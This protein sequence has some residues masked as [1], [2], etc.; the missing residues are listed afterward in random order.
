MVLFGNVSDIAAGYG[1]I[2]EHL[3]CCGTLREFLR[4]LGRVRKRPF[5][6]L[7]SPTFV[8][9]RARSKQTSSKLEPCL[10]LR[11]KSTSWTSTSW[12]LASIPAPHEA[13]PAG[14]ASFRRCQLAGEGCEGCAMGVWLVLVVV[15]IGWWVGWVYGWCGSWCGSWVTGFGD[16]VYLTHNRLWGWEE[17]A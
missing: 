11:A 7:T 9:A 5:G 17:R 2:G 12:T 10:P 14:F 15:V 13:K 3:I 6:S 16:R 1:N 4:K 8:C